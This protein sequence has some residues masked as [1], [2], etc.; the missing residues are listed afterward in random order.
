[1]NRETTHPLVYSPNICKSQGWAEPEARSRQHDPGV[2]P[3]WQEPTHFS[4]HHCLQFDSAG[5]RTA[6]AAQRSNGDT[7]LLASRL[8]ADAISHLLCCSGSLRSGKFFFSPSFL[9]SP[10]CLSFSPLLPSVLL[11]FFLFPFLTS[12]FSLSFSPS[13]IIPFLIPFW[14]SLC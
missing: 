5:A 12:F 3:G 9:F 10:S 8:C 1:M 14:E 4:C 2:L 7:G 11:S 6:N 13:F